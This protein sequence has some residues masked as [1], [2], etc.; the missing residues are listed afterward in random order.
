[1]QGAAAIGAA[2]GIGGAMWGGTWGAVAVGAAFAA[3]PLAVFG[4]AALVA[5]GSYQMFRSIDAQK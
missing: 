5:Y 4:M 3:A 1:M 2:A